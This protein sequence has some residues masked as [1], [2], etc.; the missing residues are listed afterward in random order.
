MTI[1]ELF[2]PLNQEKKKGV[3]VSLG[4]DYGSEGEMGT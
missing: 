2:V 1:S 3:T 4:I